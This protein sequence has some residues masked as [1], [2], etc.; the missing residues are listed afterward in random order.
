[1]VEHK[2]DPRTVALMVEEARRVIRPENMEK[3]RVGTKI[4]GASRTGMAFWTVLLFRCFRIARRAEKEWGPKKPPSGLLLRMA[5]PPDLAEEAIANFDHYY[6][7]VW[8][9]HHSA[10]FARMV[11]ASQSCL[12]LLAHYAELIKSVL[13]I[14]IAKRE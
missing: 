5:L 12:T 6:E 8:L 1:M 10:G 4:F 13:G 7:T 2:L 11:Y 3:W 14:L 9:K